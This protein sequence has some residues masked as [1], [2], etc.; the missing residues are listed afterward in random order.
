MARHTALVATEFNAGVIAKNLDGLPGDRSAPNLVA[1]FTQRLH[2][3][4]HGERLTGTSSAFDDLDLAFLG[5]I[6]NG[7]SLLLRQMQG[8]LNGQ[9]RSVFLLLLQED[10]LAL[11]NDAFDHRP[12]KGRGGRCHHVYLG[13][14]LPFAVDDVLSGEEA[15]WAFLA[16]RDQLLVTSNLVVDAGLDCRSAV[17]LHGLINV[18]AHFPL[19]ECDFVFDKLIERLFDDIFFN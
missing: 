12:A 4:T 3:R 5:R 14:H 2:E 15:V 16:K 18:L 1:I 7:I 17:D 11:G 6:A 9:E 13:Q 10:G 8:F 19:G